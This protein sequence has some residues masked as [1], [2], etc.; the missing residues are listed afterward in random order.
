MIQPDN[1]EPLEFYNGAEKLIRNRAEYP[2]AMLLDSLMDINVNVENSKR[3]C[4]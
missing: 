4:H 1:K 3:L 2:H